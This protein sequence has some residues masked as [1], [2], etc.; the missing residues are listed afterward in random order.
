[1]RTTCRW[2][3]ALVLMG[4]GAAH[5]AD[6]GG[7]TKEGTKEETKKATQGATKA[8]TMEAA[9]AQYDSER[10]RCLAGATGQDQAACLKSAGAAYDAFRQDRLHDA[11]SDYR[12]NA[13]ARCQRLPTADRADCMARIDGAGTTS[14]SVTGGG[15]L[16]ETVTPVPAPSTK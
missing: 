15:T 14:G 5:A 11:D 10:A 16:T 8:A 9:K 3:I 6:G 13:S 2:M 1:M 12:D 7:A 4:C